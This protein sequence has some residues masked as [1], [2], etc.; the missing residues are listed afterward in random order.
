MPVV[1]VCPSG[2]NL[3]IIFTSDRK[4]QQFNYQYRKVNRPTD[5]L[6]FP[7]STKK[8]IKADIFISVETARHQAKQ[9]R[10]SFEQEILFL[11]IH[12][13]L[14]LLGWRDDTDKSRIA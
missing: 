11:L 2:C 8:I 12:G 9:Y 6:C 1:G 13:I 4:I 5:V 14:H 10:K 3:G 7:Y